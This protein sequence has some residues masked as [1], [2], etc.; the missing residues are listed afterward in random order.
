MP[1]IKPVALLL[2]SILFALMLA[3][4]AAQDTEPLD[5]LDDFAEVDGLEYAV[6]RIWMVDFET[7]LAASPAAGMAAPDLFFTM[8]MVWRMDSTEHAE[9]AFTFLEEDGTDDLLQDDTANVEM[10]DLDGIGDQASTTEVSSSDDDLE[11]VTRISIAQEG[12]YVYLVMSLGGNSASV[13]N[14]DLVLGAMVNDADPSDG[15]GTLAE[16]GTSTGGIWD[17]FPADDLDALTGLINAGD[18]IMY[19]EPE[20]AA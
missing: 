14:A 4:A 10:S 20:D 15:D 3:P 16:D 18:S 17:T 5:D 8:A 1:R 6:S 12:E 13:A 19:P 2:A 9:E 11:G 7:M